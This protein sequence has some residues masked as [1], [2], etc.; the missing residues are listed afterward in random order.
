MSGAV[1]FRS[2]WKRYARG[3]RHDALRDLVPALLRRLRG[4]DRAA[5]RRE[6]FWALSDVSFDVGPGEALGIIGPNGA[7]KST[8][9]KLAS[10]ILRAERGEVDVRGRVASLI[11]LVAGFHSELTGRENI[12][13]Q[14]A[15]LGMKRAE[16]RRRFDRI[17]EF[18]G[19]G[20]FL[21]TPVKRYSSGMH[22]RLGFSIAAHTDPD[23]LLID[24][25][26]AV[27]DVAFQRKAAA[28]MSEILRRDIAVV[29]VSHQMEKILDLCDRA[30]LLTAGRVA[31]AGTASECVEA[32]L[33]EAQQPSAAP[34]CPVSLVDGAE[35]SPREV[36][37][38]GRVQ[39]TIPGTIAGPAAARDAAIGVCVRAVGPENVVFSTDTQAC[40]LEL[41]PEG[42]F[43][44]EVELAMNLAPGLY[45]LQ[46]MVWHA[47]RQTEWTSGPSF[48]LRVTGRK[49]SYGSTFLAPRLRLRGSEE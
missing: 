8:V 19:V 33:G 29:L 45:R 35:P 46:P 16:I 10:G 49:E 47:R 28:R 39:L 9:L 3:E 34:D 2:V 24:E 40:G 12:Y 38:G 6:E 20:P 37:C 11:E 32:Y 13:L 7:G 43:A 5:S 36:S 26:L 25:V 23:V 27:G 42:D 21:D 17:V 18:S 4:G 1:S 44:L 41:P 31:T 48:L 30:L 14:G 22:L 15:V